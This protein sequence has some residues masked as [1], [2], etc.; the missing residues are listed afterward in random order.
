M[1]ARRKANKNARRRARA[2]GATEVEEIDSYFVRQRDNEL[3][4]LCGR[5]VSV[6]DASLDHV[7]PLA[8]GGQHTLDNV[9]LAHKVCNSKKGDRLLG[10]IDWTTF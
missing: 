7:V 6:H 5:W 4:H 3:C 10:E 1:R 8:K 2:F 9:K